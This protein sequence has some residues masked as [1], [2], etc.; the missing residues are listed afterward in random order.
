MKKMLC[1]LLAVLLLAS[2]GV[3]VLAEGNGAEEAGPLVL[4]KPELGFRFVV[5]EKYR[6]LKGS[7]DWSSHYLDD[8]IIQITLSYYS[9]PEEDF[10]AY[11]DFVNALIEAL[12]AGE[13]APEP[14]DPKW[15]TGMEC[16][17]LYD[18]FTINA[19]RGEEELRE[20]LKAHNGIREDNF[21]WFEKVGSDGEFSFFVGQYAEL[22]ENRDEYREAMGEEYYAELEDI[23]SDRETFLDALTLSAPEYEMNRLETDDM[24]SFETTDLDGNPVNSKDLFAGSRVTMINLWATW[25]MACKKELPELNE[26]AKEFEK[27]GCRIVGICL[28]ADEEGMDELAKEI[29]EKNGVDYLN[30]VPPENVDELLPAVS[31]PTSFFFDSEG[32]MIT[33]PVRGAYVDQY[34]PT[35]KDALVSLDSAAPAEGEREAP[36][37]N[38]VTLAN[39]EGVYRVIVS[40]SDGNP[41]KG[42]T[43]K[44]CSDTT[45]TMGK[46]DADGVAVFEME[47]GPIYNIHVLKVP[48]GYVKNDGEYLTDDTFC[49]VHIPLEKAA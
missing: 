11:N 38:G 5:P 42:V 39:G 9:F 13:D 44:F 36:E 27:M 48:E 41:V 45:C 33:E 31:F 21:G 34:L 15:S 22:E 14:A 23:A 2:V 49:D 7:L 8:G 4:D 18:I 12:L 1:I 37:E 17:Y 43:I 19:D 29:L 6:N 30:L 10:D 35:L 16:A 20:E 46:T 3:P 24:V 32:R 25:C 40:D 28:D 26:L 47:E